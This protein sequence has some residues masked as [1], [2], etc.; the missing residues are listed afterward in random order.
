[1]DMMHTV[2]IILGLSL[3][4]FVVMMNK[5]ASVRRILFG[6]VALYALIC[7][8]VRVLAV[9]VGYSASFLLE[10][11]VNDRLELSIACLIIFSIGLYLIFRGLSRREPEEKL[12][13]LF[14]LRECFFL[15]VL[16]S[17][18]TLLLAVGFSL[19]DIALSTVSALTFVITF[20]GVL[21]SFAIGY[22]EG[23]HFTRQLSITGGSLMIVLSL[24]L[25]T[26]T[27]MLLG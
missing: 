13:R 12:D 9:L 16:T 6:R 26:H 23:P 4:S 7:A 22:F 20:V 11:A 21:A 18:E 8:V 24:Y 14:G 15:A 25:M 1:M 17:I 10:D 27:V 3:D 2:M 19:F 5:G